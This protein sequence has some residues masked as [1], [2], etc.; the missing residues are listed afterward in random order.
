VKTIHK[1]RHFFLISLALVLALVTC[2]KTTPT[3]EQAVATER[4]PAVEDHF[5]QG[6]ELSQANEFEKAIDEY[7]QAL[8]INSNDVDVLANLGVA[9]YN[10]GHWDDAIEQ[11]LKAIEISPDDADIHSNLAA[12]YVQKHQSGG[13]ADDLD[14][15]LE[16]YQKAVDI[17]KDLA[18]AHFG[19]GVVYL[20]MGRNEDAIKALEKFQELDEGKDPM[21]TDNAKQYLEQLRGQ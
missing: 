20:L 3:E 11:Y 17:K 1:I 5:R 16:E 8:E 10:L 19:L 18:E 9:H 7:R 15:A 2:G 6:N 4:P 14:R 21:A 12:A 13:S